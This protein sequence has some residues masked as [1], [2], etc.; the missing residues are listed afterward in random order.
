MQHHLSAF[1]LLCLVGLAAAQRPPYAPNPVRYP[2]VAPRFRTPESDAQAAVDLAS[3]SGGLDV[4]TTTIRLPVDARGNVDVVNQIQQ[5]PE[6]KRPFWY[7][8]AE[9]IEKSRSNA[10]PAPG[11]QPVVNPVPARSGFLPG[12]QN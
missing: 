11:Q 7:I 2:D 6:D 4:S 8:N 3:R 10:V 9:A 5:W 1:A 12:T